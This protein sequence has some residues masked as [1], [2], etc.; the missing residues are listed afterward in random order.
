MKIFSLVSTLIALGLIAPAHAVYAFDLDSMIEAAKGGNGTYVETHSS[1]STGGQTSHGGENVQTG[2]AS[3]SS[4]TEIHAGEDGGT[5][6]VKI[7]TTENGETKTKEFMHDIP[8]GEGV[9]VEANA[10][11]TDGEA[12]SEVK[13]NDEVLEVKSETHSATT[14]AVVGF[15]TETIPGLFKKVVGF[16]ADL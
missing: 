2:D 13:V 9:K 1:V 8:K 12:S 3:V 10:E 5:V 15:F 11:S 6:K 7:E 14:S 16:F 4:H